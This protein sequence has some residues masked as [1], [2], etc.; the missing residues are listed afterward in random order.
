MSLRPAVAC[1]G[2]LAWSLMGCADAGSADDANGDGAGG[3]GDQGGDGGVVEDCTTCG[4]D[5]AD[6]GDLESLGSDEGDVIANLGMVDQCG[7]EVSLWDFA[8]EWHILWMTAEW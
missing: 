7:E 3:Q 1:Y 5:C 2:L 8:Q 4:W 6:P